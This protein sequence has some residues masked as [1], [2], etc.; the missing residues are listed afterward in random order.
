MQVIKSAPLYVDYFRID[1]ENSE[2]L[3]QLTNPNLYNTPISEYHMEFEAKLKISSEVIK[4]LQIIKPKK[5][6]LGYRINME[7]LFYYKEMNQILLSNFIEFLFKFDQTELSM[8]AFDSPDFVLKFNN[9]VWKVVKS[10]NEYSYARMDTLT[11]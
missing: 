10:N 11:I 3:E 5:I 1:A 6:V 8:N 7:N 9:A 4:N 2:E